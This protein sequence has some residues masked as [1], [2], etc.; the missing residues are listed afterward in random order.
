MTTA[1]TVLADTSSYS[2][3]VCPLSKSQLFKLQT[4][5]CMAWTL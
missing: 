3:S 5:C 2:A 4:K 1:E